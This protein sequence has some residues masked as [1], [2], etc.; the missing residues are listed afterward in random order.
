M[1]LT[2]LNDSPKELIFQQVA[3]YLVEQNLK[4]DKQ[5]DSRPWGGFFVIEENEAEKFINLYFPNLSKD[6]LNISGR[7][8]PK[9]LIVAPDKRLSWQY[10]HRR[11]EIWKLIGGTAGVVI[12]DTDEEK[13]IRH[14]ITGDIIH[15]KQGERHRLLGLKGWGI[16]AEIWRHTDAEHPSDEEDIVRVQDDF[17]R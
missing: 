17:G 14:L 15:L 2:F 1:K 8:S 6:K 13:E 11:A 4:I 7:L 5:D 3:D 9:I 10:H 12:S 16:I